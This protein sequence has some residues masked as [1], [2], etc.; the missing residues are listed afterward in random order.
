VIKPNAAE[1]AVVTG[2]PTASDRSGEGRD[3]GALPVR[4]ARDTGHP[5]PQGCLSGAREAPVRHFQ[6]SPRKC[7]TF[8][9]PAIRPRAVGLALARALPWRRPWSFAMLASGVV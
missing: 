1:L 4:S 8:P 3:A 6:G 5:G 7:S 2:M 9:A